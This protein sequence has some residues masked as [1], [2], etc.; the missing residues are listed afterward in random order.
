M[1]A[2]SGRTLAS[3]AAA[4]ADVCQR[5]SEVM[6]ISD[7]Q[8]FLAAAD[9]ASP[10]VPGVPNNNDRSHA[11]EKRIRCHRISLPQ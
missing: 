4:V 6:S 11:P 2:P 7:D 10:L 1:I 9:T 5:G 3:M 8:G